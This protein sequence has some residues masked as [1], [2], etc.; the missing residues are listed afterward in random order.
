MKPATRTATVFA[1]AGAAMGCI[2]ILAGCGSTV[3]A[4]PNSSAVPLSA[5]GATQVY[6]SQPAF[7]GNAS[8]SVVQFPIGASD[9]A[10]PTTT[11]ATPQTNV[12]SYVAADKEGHI[13]VGA[14]TASP[15]VLVFPAGASGSASPARTISGSAASFSEAGPLAVDSESNLYVIDPAGSISIFSPTANGAAPPERH[16]QGSLTQLADSTVPNAISVDVFGNIYVSLASTSP[17]ATAWKIL[18]FSPSAEGNIA[19]ARVISAENNC[20][21]D[22]SFRVALDST[23]NF[24][25]ACIVENETAITEFASNGSSV[26]APVKTIIGTATATV[27][28][29]SVDNAGNVYAVCYTQ[30]EGLSLEAFSA[31]GS[32]NITPAVRFTSGSLTSV[33]PQLAVR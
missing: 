11:L 24:Y 28:A 6:I 13:Y 5:G 27:V 33:F 2:A 10:V 31:A 1:H 32:G 18:V 4:A 30:N 29:L 20:S 8:G 14:G 12:N 19:P 21:L 25:V 9:N 23:G 26:A 3:P 22:N 15:K 16:I 7:T 17:N